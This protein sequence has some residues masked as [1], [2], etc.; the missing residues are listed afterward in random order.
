MKDN[1]KTIISWPCLSK[2]F[3]LVFMLK[4]NNNSYKLRMLTFDNAKYYVHADYNNY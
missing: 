3:T 1:N 4:N 2:V